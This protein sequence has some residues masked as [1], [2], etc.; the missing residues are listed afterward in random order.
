MA[1][2][3]PRDA[4]ITLLPTIAQSV[5][6]SPDSSLPPAVES[7]LRIV[8]VCPPEQ[9][10]GV[11]LQLQGGAGGGV[12]EGGGQVT[13]V[14]VVLLA[15][16][17]AVGWRKDINLWAWNLFTYCTPLQHCCLVTSH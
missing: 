4:I 6:L 2:I 3:P 1:D 14:A 10:V 12:M 8:V 9:V 16:M 7:E 15:G 17:T 13:G 5:S 11:V